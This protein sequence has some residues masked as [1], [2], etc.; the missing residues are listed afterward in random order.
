MLLSISNPNSNIKGISSS[1]SQL[2]DEVT[3]D[4]AS[5]AASQADVSGLITELAKVPKKDCKGV[6]TTQQIL[7]ANC[8]TEAKWCT[9]IRVCGEGHGE[10]SRI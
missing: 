1:S 3:T 2:L 4:A 5:R 10:L 7:L 8:C 6:S 9:R